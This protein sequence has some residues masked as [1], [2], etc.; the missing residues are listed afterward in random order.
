LAD[1]IFQQLEDRPLTED[2]RN[3]LA[4]QARTLGL[5]SLR[6]WFGSIERDPVHSGAYYMAVDGLAGA[7][8]EPLLLHFSPAAA[9]VGA[10]FPK[11]LLIG[12]MRPTG[13]RELLINATPFGPGDSEAVE[14]FAR[15]VNP[16]LLP[17]PQ[18]VRP[19]LRIETVRAGAVA[20]AAFQAFR[21]IFKTLGRNVAAFTIPPG[22]QDFWA[23]VWAAV[24]AGYRD[25]YG[26]GGPLTPE[27]AGLFTRF[28]VP[29]RDL[30]E[31]AARLRPLRSGAPFDLEAVPEPGVDGLH[32]LAASGT[33]V[34]AVRVPGGLDNLESVLD[35]IRA[36]GALPCFSE[37][38][39]YTAETVGALRHLTLGRLAF[40]LRLDEPDP[41]HIVGTAETLG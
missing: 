14:T 2:L 15:R 13:G 11:P 39:G 5:Q 41:A 19:S 17:R 7:T 12:R 9:P 33:H 32:A 8:A 35:A 26:V 34:Q 37:S 27:S 36:T 21:T 18:G 31:A 30:P 4:G 22:R 40:S 24:R 29:A 16:A 38:D 23:V 20:P 25:G 6:P 3:R 28:V 1:L 10:L